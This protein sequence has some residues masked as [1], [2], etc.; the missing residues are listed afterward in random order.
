M[1]T[2]TDPNL[3]SR[4]LSFDEIPMVDIA[5]LV[6][7]S[8]PAKVAREIGH[9]CEH[10]GFLYVTNH[11]VPRSLIDDAYGL[12]RSFFARP[13]EEK[14]TLNIRHSGPTLRGY[15]PTYGENVDPEKS[16]DFKE[17]FDLGQHEEEISPFFG[18]NPMPDEPSGFKQVFETYHA[19][20]LALSRKLVSAIALSLDLPADYFARL[21]RRP[22]TVQRLLHYPSQDGEVR[23][24]EIGIGAHTDYGFLT[25]LSQDDNGGLQVRNREGHWISAP[26]IEDTFVV[27]IGD[28]VQTFTNDRY[29]STLH[30]VVNTTGAGRYSLPFFIDLDYDAVVD[31]LPNCTSEDNPPRYSPYTSGAHKYRRYVNSYAH[32]QAA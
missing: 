10:I 26:P 16:R 17:C 21:Q 24:N 23:E 32:L 2:P 8:N 31:V 25:I 3:S 4:T 29:V 18:P 7:G 13:F 12:S 6:D 11:G 14:N 19:E 22:I 28:L 9:I 1:S 5:P 15:I 30:R 20:M 27:N